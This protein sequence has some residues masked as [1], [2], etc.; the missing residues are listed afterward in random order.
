MYCQLIIFCGSVAG[1]DIDSGEYASDENITWRRYDIQRQYIC[2]FML[3][4]MT[5]DVNIYCHISQLLQKTGFHLCKVVSQPILEYSF[6][7]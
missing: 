1:Q 6:F 2:I 5:N 4:M 7:S 3:S